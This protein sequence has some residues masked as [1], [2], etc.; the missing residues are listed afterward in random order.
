MTRNSSKY[1][2]KLS[3]V[4][5]GL[6]RLGDSILPGV[7]V[8][9]GLQTSPDDYYICSVCKGKIRNFG[10]KKLVFPDK[11]GVNS[12]YY[13]FPYDEYLGVDLGNAVRVLKYE[14]HWRLASEL[15]LLL[16]EVMLNYPVLTKADLITY[17]P[18]HHARFRERGFNQSELIARQLAEHFPVQC[19]NLLKRMRNTPQQMELSTGERELNVKGV[20]S[21]EAGIGVEDK[22]IIIID[23]QITTGATLD[24][25]G[26]ALLRSGASWV[27]C[28]TLTH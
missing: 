3:S 24:N 10:G 8:C 20:F 22:G 15:S 5:R 16:I 17:V 1:S 7:C 21:P 23:D 4:F 14:G 25:A 2:L 6:R 12:A 26:E 11:T 9:C 18:L 27:T 28:L 19:S 13:L